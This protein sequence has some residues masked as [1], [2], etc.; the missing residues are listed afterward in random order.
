M[1]SVNDGNI[2]KEPS[3]GG[4]GGASPPFA[5]SDTTGL[6]TA[7]DSKEPTI[8]TLALSKGG[9]NANLSATGGTGQVLKQKTVGGA[10]Q[11][12]ALGATDIRT[13]VTGTPAT[14][15]AITDDGSSGLAWAGPFEPAIT[16]L[17]KSKGGFGASIASVADG[18][19]KFVSG[20][21]TSVAQLGLAQGGTNAD[22]SASGGTTHF[23]AQD[24]S[25]VVSARALVPGDSPHQLA[26]F[27]RTGSSQSVTGATKAPVQFNTESI[28]ELGVSIASGVI[29][30]A[31]AGR[32]RLL[33]NGYITG[34]G[35]MGISKANSATTYAGLDFIRGSGS[36]YFGQC[37]WEGDLAASDAIRCLIELNSNGDIKASNGTSVGDGDATW[38]TIERLK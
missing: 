31:N 2:T 22:L 11:V 32:Y 35:Y 26:I 10:I 19:L 7:L 14:G 3:D 37:S 23:L 15:K 13:P 25:H 12:E 6:Q 29:T 8:A 5:I 18:V 24:A 34:P 20:V 4:S 36:D 38:L 28:D 16:T 33:F 21:L 1:S 30:F 9:T 17:A 27:R